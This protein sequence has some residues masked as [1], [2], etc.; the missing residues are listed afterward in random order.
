LG[1]F[2]ETLANVGKNMAK[3]MGEGILRKN[4]FAHQ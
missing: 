4:T 1:H 2:A 3:S